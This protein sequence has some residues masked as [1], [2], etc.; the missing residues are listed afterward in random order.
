MR[1]AGFSLIEML[2]AL[3]ITAMLATAGTLLLVQTVRGGRTVEERTGET[4]SLDVAHSLVRDDLATATTRLTRGPDGL[5]VPAGLTGGLRMANG[6]L[7]GFTR[8]SW[9]NPDMS[10]ERGDLQRIEYLMDDDRLVRRAW[11]RPDPVRET[12]YV[13]RVLADGL[14]DAGIRFFDGTAWRLSWYD[15]EGGLPDLIELT[16]VFGEGDELRQLFLVGGAA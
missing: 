9:A 1:T 3:A 15:Q 10:E 8:A 14:Q 13:D 5:D 4:R 12:P 2:V 11:L 16:F 6:R 7:L